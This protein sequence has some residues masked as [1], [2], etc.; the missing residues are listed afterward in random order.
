MT[1]TEYLE[2]WSHLHGF[3]ENTEVAGIARA[4]LSFNY[5]LAQPAVF[6]RF[7]P[8]LVTLIAPLFAI[9]AIYSEQNLL[10]AFLVLASLMTDGLDG[11]VAIIRGKTSRI[12][13]VWDGVIDRITE[14]L[15]IG[16]LYHAGISPSLLLAIWALVA[17]QE[18]GRA[19]FN[20]VA[21]K[22]LGVVTVC[23][24]PVRGLLVAFGFLGEIF[25]S[26]SL[27]VV[28]LVWLILQGI[29]IAQFIVMTRRQ[30][31]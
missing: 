13:S 5:Y 15:W 3:Q 7:A 25:Q 11:A 1:R 17:T 18:Y 9:A 19:K 26:Q 8:N 14:L 30:L 28:S 23:E 20:H 2:K 27:E 4:Y 6:L 10:T 24:R 21:G 31:R 12:G 22:T 16:A 29:A